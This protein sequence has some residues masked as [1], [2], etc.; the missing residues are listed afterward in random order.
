M[1]YTSYNPYFCSL[2]YSTLRKTKTHIKILDYPYVTQDHF[3]VFKT[4]FKLGGQWSMAVCQRFLTVIGL[5]VFGKTFY[6]QR[7]GEFCTFCIV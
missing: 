3:F 5:M 4:G 2:L 6:L 7:S 1:V